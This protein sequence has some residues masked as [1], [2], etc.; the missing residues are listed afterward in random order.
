MPTPATN[1][2]TPTLVFVRWYR[3]ENRLDVLL[4]DSGTERLI[5]VKWQGAG[6]PEQWFETA[7]LEAAYQRNPE[8]LRGL[9]P[10]DLG[11]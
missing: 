3:A 1:G 2:R 7:A 9:T 11:G 10:G 6:L 5:V 4:D 8:S